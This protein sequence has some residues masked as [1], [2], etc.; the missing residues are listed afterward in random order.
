M[1]DL[2]VGDLHKSLLRN[3]LDPS[4][5]ANDGLSGV[6]AVDKLVTVVS[7]QRLV[8][9]DRGFVQAFE[10]GQDQLVH[11]LVEL[12]GGQAFTGE[13]AVEKTQPVELGTWD[14]LGKQQ[15]LSRLGPAQSQEKRGGGGSFGDQPQVGEGSQH[16][17]G[18]LI[19]HVHQ[20][21]QGN[22]GS[23][24]ANDRSVERTNQH[25]GVVMQQVG[26]VD[27]SAGEI[28]EP[29]LMGEDL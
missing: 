20:V 15:R 10:L 18:V 29:E 11:L 27:V 24:Q 1:L 2:L 3:A 4:V 14:G 28:F 22:N 25:L 7:E 19:V 26:Q 13:S 16:V 6:G 21:T 8:G 23:R 17:G 12:V 9:K 5:E